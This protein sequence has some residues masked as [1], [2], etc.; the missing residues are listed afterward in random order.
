[1][2]TLPAND[3]F[4]AFHLAS[5]FSILRIILFHIFLFLELPPIGIPKYMNG[6]VILMQL[7]MAS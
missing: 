3:N 6:I 2:V 7:N 4:L 1:M 5:F